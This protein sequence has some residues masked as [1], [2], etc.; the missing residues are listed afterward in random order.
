MN[1]TLANTLG[2][3]AGNITFETDNGTGTANNITLSGVL[4]GTGGLNETSAGAGILQL[5][6]ANSYQGGTT[7]NGGAV[8]LSGSGTLGNTSGALAV[9]TG[10]TLDLNGTSQTVGNLTGTGGTIVNNGT[11]TNET[12]T[13]GS[14]NGTGGNYQGVIADHTSGTGTLAFTKTG[15]GTIALSGATL[16]FNLGAALTASSL[17]LTSSFANEVT[18]LSGNTFNFADLTSGSL[19]LG[20]Y[21]L[22]QSDDSTSNPFSGL[23]LGTLTGFN[24]TGLSAYTQDEFELQLN[25]LSGSGD[26]AIQ[27]DVIPEP[28]TWVMMI[29]GLAMLVFWLRRRAG[30][31]ALP[32]FVRPP[33]NP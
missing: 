11:G 28:S 1:M 18:G 3:T 27:L 12:L 4:S 20:E 5:S 23:V 30:L 9:N 31:L 13:V 10:G 26:Y 19:A 2:T 21:T 6:G 24:I 17:S 16:S 32:G 22:I 33:S 15:T 7:V 25:Q 29:G 14:G 8:Q